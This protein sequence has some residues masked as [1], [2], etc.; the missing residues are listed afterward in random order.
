MNLSNVLFSLI[1]AGLCNQVAVS[2]SIDDLIDQLNSDQ[3]HARQAAKADLITLANSGSA[4]SLREGLKHPSLEV[5]STVAEI[6]G[7]IRQQEF[8]DQLQQVSN[9]NVP[10]DELTSTGWK[11][12]SLVAGNDMEARRAFVALCRRHP[13]GLSSIKSVSNA[14]AEFTNPFQIN[15]DDGVG[16]VLLLLSELNSPN[17]GNEFDTQ[18]ATQSSRIAMS[19][20]QPTMGLDLH[21]VADRSDGCGT[22]FSRLVTRWLAKH[23]TIIDRRTAIRVALRYDCDQT[24]LAIAENVLSVPDSPAASTVTAM[25]V[26][27]KLNQTSQKL[28]DFVD[29][30]RTAHVWQLIADRKIKIQTQVRDVAIALMLNQADQDPR[31]FGFNYL[32]ADPLLRF[33]DY[34]L[35]FENDQL[36]SMAHTKALDFLA[37][38]RGTPEQ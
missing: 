1:I 38:K 9:P 25:L 29:D 37:T 22:I 7:M 18:A 17:S 14:H 15:T 8:G 12:F 35:G 16:W 31:Q 32:E 27:A 21:A 20:S 23:D 28:S 4:D 13:T 19:L 6:L 33:R 36:R 3:Y 30:N 11:E 24:A 26:V 2:Q 34:S 5:R 10:S